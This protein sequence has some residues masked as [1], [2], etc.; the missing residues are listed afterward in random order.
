[1]PRRALCLLILVCA[2]SAFAA[3]SWDGTWAGGWED[4]DGIQIIIV[5]NKVIGVGRGDAYPDV[6]SSDASPEGRMLSFWWVGGDGFLQRTSD[7]EATI[8]VREHGKPV[9]TFTVKRE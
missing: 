8:S 1:M 6:L 9:R 5:G 7:R 3:P 4:G 2:G